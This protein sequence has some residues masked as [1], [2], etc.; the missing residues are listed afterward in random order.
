MSAHARSNGRRG[1]PDRSSSAIA[2]FLGIGNADNSW[3]RLTLQH[4]PHS[5]CSVLLE[6]L[7]GSI[8]A[9]GPAVP[10]QTTGTVSLVPLA[11]QDLRQHTALRL[12]HAGLS[13]LP[14]LVFE[15]SQ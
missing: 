4:Q 12:F 14:P 1:S 8:Q 2:W 13:L 3:L 6:E 15:R 5:W 7:A 11:P 9:A 10:R